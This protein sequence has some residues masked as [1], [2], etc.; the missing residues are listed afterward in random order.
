[1]QIIFSIVLFRRDLAMRSRA[2]LAAMLVSAVGLLFATRAWAQDATLQREITEAIDRGVAYLRKQQGK[3]G[4]WP[5]A[6]KNEQIGAS[7]SV[8]THPEADKRMVGATALAAWT[9]LECGAAADDS[10]VQ[11]AAKVLR[12]DCIRIN[13]TYA[14]SLAILFF[15]R[16][17]DPLDEPLIQSL[18]VRLI[19]SQTSNGGW[20]YGVAGREP[21]ASEV[22]RL[23]RHYEQA[24]KNTPPRRATSATH[25]LA[26]EIRF[27]LAS[28]QGPSV[29]PYPADNSN[30]QFAILAL[31][32]ARRH[33]MAG[34]P[35]DYGLMLTAKRFRDT[36]VPR[37]GCW[38]YDDFGPELAREQ[39][40][41]NAL[42]EKIK[43]K[44]GRFTAM[45]CAGLLGLALG[46]PASL[47][48]HKQTL[49]RELIHDSQI[50]AGLAAVAAF[51]GTPQVD[52]SNV[53][54]LLPGEA[55]DGGSRDQSCYCLWTIMRMA[56]V[57]DL[58]TIGNKDWY[59]W[60]AQILVNNQQG[61]GSWH[62]DCPMG[63][64]DTSFALLFLKRANVAQDLT[65]RL[66]GKVRDPGKS[67]PQILQMI[68]KEDVTRGEG[69]QDKKRQVQQG[70]GEAASGSPAATVPSDPAKLGSE[71]INAAPAQQD[72]ILEKLRDT[73]GSEY[74][75]A[76]ASVIP[77][78]RGSVKSKARQALA[79]RFE[80]LD[81]EVLRV[82][83]MA[84]ESE[85]RRAAAVAAGAKKS[86]ELGP[87]LVRLLEDHEVTVLQ[88]ARTALRQISGQDFGPELD[89]GPAERTAA[90]EAWRRY[91]RQQ[92]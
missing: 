43:L 19:T 31:W 59:A 62:S 18:A 34:M 74:T 90:I 9:L 23:R 78:L 91:W 37:L 84:P 11:K 48:N 15:D 82:H 57:Y 21:P 69:S 33:G 20:T 56:R 65:D 35:L 72:V 86:R 40:D 22:E 71:I 92:K 1:L 3:D 79:Q 64:A 88:A 28:F 38:G 16:L 12:E 85:M 58:K 49:G 36:Q 52:P 17:G 7:R 87:D 61:N 5:Y 67:S 13:Y 25:E 41:E 70:V 83:L 66:K 14:M 76:L 44:I 77:K 32:V 29:Y 47:K 73:P 27:Q 30:T 63:A 89:A 2:F 53:P 54:K 46:H 55:S 80:S 68:G 10:Q 24:P 75:T 6:P 4:R 26:P 39:P 42:R 50:N 81:A 45:T 60:G 8:L 51:I